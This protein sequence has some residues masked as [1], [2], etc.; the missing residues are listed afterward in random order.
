MKPIQSDDTRTIMIFLKHFDAAKQSLLGIGNVHL[1][2]ASK[3]SDLIPIINEKMKWAPETS[4]NLYKV[5][6]RT[7]SPT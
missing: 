6:I 7:F 3:V 2:K 1:Q 5:A 4:L